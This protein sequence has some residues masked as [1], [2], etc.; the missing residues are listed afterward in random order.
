MSVMDGEVVVFDEE[1]FNSRRVCG[2][3][4]GLVVGFCMTGGGSCDVC[5]AR[6]VMI[7]GM[8]LEG[9]GDFQWFN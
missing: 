9:G 4:G 5:W 3:K 6:T 2:G 1:R 7:M 8:I